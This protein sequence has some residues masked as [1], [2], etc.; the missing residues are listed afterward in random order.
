MDAAAQLGGGPVRFGGRIGLSGY[1]IGD[2]DLTADG[3]QMH[4]RYPEDFRSTIDAALTLRGNPAALVLGGNIIIR[5]GVYT[6]R[7]EPNVDI[8]ALTSRRR[9]AAGR[10]RPRPR[11]C[12]CASTSR[13]RRRARCAWRT[14]WRGWSRAPT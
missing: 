3:E 10:G 6:K 14:T 13:S 11:R 4:L 9:D 12:R 8:F 2:V 1:G 7:F 5:D